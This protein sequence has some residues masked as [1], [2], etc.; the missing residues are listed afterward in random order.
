MGLDTAQSCKWTEFMLV[1]LPQM[2]RKG[3]PFV[4]PLFNQYLFRTQMKGT[5]WAG[6]RLLCWHK[7]CRFATMCYLGSTRTL[8]WVLT[9]ACQQVAWHPV[10]TFWNPFFAQEPRKNPFKVWRGSP[11]SSTETLFMAPQAH[12]LPSKSCHGLQGARWLGLTCISG[13]TF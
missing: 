4:V 3:F 2:K 8:S 12:W 10:S 7:F 6:H 13:I 9:M 5:L 1:Q 11:H